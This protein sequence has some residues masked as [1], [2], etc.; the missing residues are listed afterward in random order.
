MLRV[1]KRVQY[2]YYSFHQ[3]NYCGQCCACTE[4]KGRYCAPCLLLAWCFVLLG[5]REERKSHALLSEIQMYKH[6]VVVEMHKARGSVLVVLF[7]HGTVN[8][9]ATK[10]HYC[11]LKSI[12]VL[13]SS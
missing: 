7:Q 4:R 10:M 5:G 9:A 11:T 12:L 1:I 8:H 13:R 2:N 3:G 6:Q